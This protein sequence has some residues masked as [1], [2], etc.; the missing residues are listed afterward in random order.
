M[1]NPRDILKELWD[2]AYIPENGVI[3]AF[4]SYIQREDD[5]CF[6]IIEGGNSYDITKTKYSV[7]EYR[8]LDHPDSDVSSDIAKILNESLHGKLSHV[9]IKQLAE[10]I[11]DE[12]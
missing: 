11:V 5:G 6:Y 1:T 2:S 3:P 9:E 4:C 7:G 10:K 8:L 12:L